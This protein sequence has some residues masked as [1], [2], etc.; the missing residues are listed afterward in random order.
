MNKL[1][2][3]VG[4][5]ALTANADMSLTLDP[6]VMEEAKRA[7]FNGEEA[8]LPTTS[9]VSEHSNADVALWQQA[10]DASGTELMPVYLLALLQKLNPDKPMVE[11]ADV[12]AEALR[13]H[14]LAAAGNKTA[15]KQLA[16]ALQSGVL[17]CG[18]RIICDTDKAAS[19]LP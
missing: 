13:L 14:M 7:V 4:M 12:Y 19:L 8:L 15:K 16:V 5:L 11:H 18:L 3:L 10:M 17:P 1:L 9:V 6:A 2:L